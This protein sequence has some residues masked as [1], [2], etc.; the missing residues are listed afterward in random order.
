MTKLV[1]VQPKGQAPRPGTRLRIQLQQD[2]DGRP[3]HPVGYAEV[4][5]GGRALL[6]LADRQE[7]RIA[8]ELV[9]EDMIDVVF[10]GSEPTLRLR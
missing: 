8:A 6:K 2:V 1:W 7:G 3:L 10:W 5:R 9:R 4:Y